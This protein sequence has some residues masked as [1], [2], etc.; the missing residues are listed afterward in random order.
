MT[1][2]QPLSKPV[3]PPP[4]GDPTPEPAP[5]GQRKVVSKKTGAKERKK[6]K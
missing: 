5:T 3:K 4:L 6:E 2:K 1:K